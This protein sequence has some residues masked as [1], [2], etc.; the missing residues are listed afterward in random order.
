MA[1]GSVVPVAA[2][3]TVSSWVLQAGQLLLIVFWVVLV[4]RSDKGRP[5]YWTSRA[6]AVPW[7][8]A[9]TQLPVAAAMV[10]NWAP[11][12]CT[13]MNGGVAAPCSSPICVTI[14]MCAA[15]AFAAACA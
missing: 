5:A 11:W 12:Y 1:P 14:G 10:S 15:A 13:A 3:W 4:I 8:S 6:F 7:L 9:I 2:S